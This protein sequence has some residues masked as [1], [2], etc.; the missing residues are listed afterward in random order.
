MK[1][2]LDLIF[3]EKTGETSID[4][5][6]IDSSLSVLEFNEEIRSGNILNKALEKISEVFGEQ[7]ANRVRSGE[8]A[9]I[10]LDNHPELK[11]NDSG[12]LLTEEATNKVGGII[13]N[14]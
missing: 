14:Q 3:N 6:V 2:L 13:L 12:I 1:I 7:I 10:C 8:I 5:E 9:A 11:R 4:V